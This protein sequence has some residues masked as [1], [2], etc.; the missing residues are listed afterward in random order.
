MGAADT[1]LLTLLALAEACLMIHLY[2]RR[3]RRYRTERMMRSLRTAIQRETGTDV[4]RVASTP[5]TLVLQRAS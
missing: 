4:L 5:Q 3:Q 2:R 1:M